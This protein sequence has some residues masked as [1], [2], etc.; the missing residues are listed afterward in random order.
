MKKCAMVC[1]EAAD[2]DGAYEHVCGR[3]TGLLGIM[4]DE[5][6]G[7]DDTASEVGCTRLGDDRGI[8]PGEDRGTEEGGRCCN[9]LGE[10]CCTT[11][12]GGFEPPVRLVRVGLF[13]EIG[14]GFRLDVAAGV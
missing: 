5:L 12:N 8:T 6:V 2:D 3:V 9:A 1:C 14:R 10:V 11:A 13:P 4:Y 7:V